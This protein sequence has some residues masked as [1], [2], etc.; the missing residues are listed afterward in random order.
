MRKF[1]Y[2]IIIC[3]VALLSSGCERGLLD[4]IS[5]K[6]LPDTYVLDTQEGLEKLLI[7][8]YDDLQSRYY[9]G[10]VLYLYE[11][12]KGPDFFQRSVGGGYAFRVENRYGE[13]SRLNGN[14]FN[15]WKTIYNVI[16]NTTIIIDSIDDVTGDIS[17]LR[18]IKGEA[19]ALRGLAYF[20][21]LRLFSH[22]PKFSCSWG[23]AYK[24]PPTDPALYDDS[25]TTVIANTEYYCWGVP[26]VENMEM[27]FN[28]LDYR[29][30]RATADESW[31]YVCEQLEKAYSMLDGM[32]S[33]QGRINA[34]AVLGLR[35]RVALFMEDYLSV[36]ELGKEWMSKYESNYGLIS[37]DNWAA[38]YYKP[39]NSESIWEL[40]Y[41]Q[42]DNLGANS[43]NYWA[44][45]LTY[46]APG[47]PEDGT[48]KENIGYAKLGLTSGSST[49]GYE[50]LTKYGEIDVRTYLICDLGV[51][52]T[53]YKAI[54]KYV[55][56]PYHF[57]HNIPVIRLPEIYLNMS[58]AYFKMGNVVLANE[59]LS[60]VTVARRK[61]EAS[62]G[63]VEDI[64][65]ERRREFIFEGQTYWDW[66]RN[67]RK[68]TG[69]QIIES[70]TSNGDISFPSTKTVYPIPLA[71]LNAN[72]AIRNQQN[73][74]YSA[75]YL[76]TEQEE[77]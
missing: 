20:D 55:G 77:E 24:V 64:L 1:I 44:R 49:M 65:D 30:K 50:N 36:V 61:A 70:I 74:G 21:L 69:R 57:V 56:D 54:R 67:G 62:A 14:A 32:A 76:A 3:A 46:Q 42:D 18:R 71:E 17:A 25:G 35:T 10:G 58:E 38:Q 72:P 41:S 75:W 52:G 6:A 60:R 47:L 73:P 37:H 22:P 34:A 29:V 26:I 19:Y 23:S 4:K 39:F 27:G 28:I 12:C 16:R 43:I 63:L 66:A 2:I 51:P 59:Y 33:E 9:Y 68:I 15:A 40:K 8:C 53:D 48:V 7:G 11:A 13:G 31:N 45:K 5:Y